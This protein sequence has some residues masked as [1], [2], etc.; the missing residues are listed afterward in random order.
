MNTLSG[1][2][3]IRFS[4]ETFK[5]RP[6]FL[7]GA[8]VVTI[9]ISWAISFLNG[10]VTALAGNGGF[11]GVVGIVVAIVP[12]TLLG[13]G[14]TA[15]FLKA[16]DSVESVS[17]SELWHPQ[18]FWS[19]LG[20]TILNGLI[21]VGGFILLIVPGIIFALMFVFTLYAVIDRDLGPIG[22]LKESARITK[23]NRLN[24]L[25]LLGLVLL[26][27]IAGLVALIVGLL[28]TIPVS[29]LAIVHAYRTLSA[30]A[31]TPAA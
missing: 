3:C 26:L 15:F 21:V 25:G 16:H 9:V 10:F 14:M 7:I 22:A 31:G 30:R 1:S 28:V 17:L 27:N 5:K 13:M 19:Y 20:A 2:E 23:G 18:P 29:T 6:W 12:Q 11:G 4:W 24:V 8:F